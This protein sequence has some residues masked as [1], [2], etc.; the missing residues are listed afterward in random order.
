M[1]IGIASYST[2]TVRSFHFFNQV[3]E[4]GER[5]LENLGKVAAHAEVFLLW[6]RSSGTDE[7]FTER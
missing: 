3:E 2:L 5:V 1:D 6:S 7:R 4:I